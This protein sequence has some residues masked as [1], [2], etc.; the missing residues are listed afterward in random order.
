M[1]INILDYD[2][3]SSR[4]D[5]TSGDA[6]TLTGIGQHLYGRGV[7]DNKGVYCRENTCAYSSLNSSHTG[8]ILASAV[9]AAD[10]LERGELDLD[11]VLLLE[12]EEEVVRNG[13]QLQLV[14]R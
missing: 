14:N 13:D 11:F 10:L 9:A 3:V 8:P 1:L 12:G 4:G 6:F 2:V 5:W 7:I